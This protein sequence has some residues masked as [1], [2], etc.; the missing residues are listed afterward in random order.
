MRKRKLKKAAVWLLLCTMAAGLLSGMDVKA[1]DVNEEQSVTSITATPSEV[2]EFGGTVEL[3]VTG[4]GLTA[5]NWGVEASAYIKGAD[6]PV[7]KLDAEV[8]DITAT[9]AT[10]IIPTNTMKNDIEYKII[11]GIKKDGKI[12]KQ[13]ETTVVM[14]KKTVSTTSL[15]VK[16]AELV[17]QNIVKLTVAE[18]IEMAADE[19]TVKKLIYIADYPSGNNKRA[20]TADDEIAVENNSVTI[21]F[22]DALDLTQVS[23]LYIEERALKV[24]EGVV[25]AKLFHLITSSPRITRI[26]LNRDVMDYEGG[27]V[28]ATLKGV[29]VSEIETDSISASVL[30]AGETAATDIPV[31]IEEGIGD[32]PT[33]TFTVPENT[34]GNTQSYVLK[35]TVDGLPVYEGGGTNKA[36]K[37]VVSVMAKGTTGTEQ[38]LSAMNITGNNKIGEDDG[39]D[40]TV[41]VSANVGEL[42][43]TLRLYGTN[44]DP[45]KTKVRAIDENGIIFPVYNIAE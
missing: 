24:K 3:Q 18:D 32:G 12:E 41:D 16:S 42:K 26:E 7:S 39:K 43:T 10:I 8:A 36:E 45:K 29:R 1:A 28:T 9:G 21:T 30:N 13:A 20:L 5:D 37:A 23:A 22:Q 17:E 35:V 19:E 31:T 25:N 15:T 34:T 27:T 11:A 2:S 33:L 4:K 40:I 38:T 6:Y 44:L 14:A